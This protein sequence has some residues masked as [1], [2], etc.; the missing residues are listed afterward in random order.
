MRQWHFA[1][2]CYQGIPKTFTSVFFESEE[3]CMLSSREVCVPSN[4]GAIFLTKCCHI[5]KDSDA[6]LE[7]WNSVFPAVEIGILF[8]QY[9]RMMRLQL[10]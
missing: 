1:E 10:S 9:V 7:E 2:I 8:S 4:E 6:F 3:V 5:V